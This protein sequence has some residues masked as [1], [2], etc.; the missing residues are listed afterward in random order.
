P[1]NEVVASGGKDGEIY[2]WNLNSG[3]FIKKLEKHSKAVLSLAFSPDSQILASASYSQTIKI[4]NWRESNVIQ[5]L[6]T[7]PNYTQCLV[8]SQHSQRLLSSNSQGNIC[9]WKPS[10]INQ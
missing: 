3:T 4:H 7:Y 2:L 6:E 8:F 1:N 9:T 10:S 5:T